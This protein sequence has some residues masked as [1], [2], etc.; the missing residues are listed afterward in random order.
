V[1][2]TRVRQKETLMHQTFHPPMTARQ[3]RGFTLV[4]LLVVIGIIALLISMLLPSL[5][6]ARQAANAAACLSNM[7]QIGQ[8]ALMFAN[9][10]KG[11]LPKNWN[12]A[13]PN[14]GDTS[15]EY[16]YPFESWEYILSLYSSKNVFRC[17][18]D[19][20]GKLRGQWTTQDW[21]GDK[22][23][24][25]DIPL[26]YRWN[27]SHFPDND[28][29]IKLSQ[30]RNSTQ[31]ILAAEGAMV[32]EFPENWLATWTSNYDTRVGELTPE[33]AAYNRHGG[34]TIAQGRS[35][36]VFADGHA[37]TLDWAETWKRIGGTDDQPETMWRTKW[38]G[39]KWNGGQPLTNQSP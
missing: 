14:W 19:D 21:A 22:W 8:A 25:D 1:P 30:L 35:N 3:R 23:E 38:L 9:D 2:Q 31:A 13:G 18:S 20:T 32:A 39:S 11:Y 5:N 15:W 24:D 28:T 12:N 37:E 17:P 4:E 6:K 29:G 36:F 34:K 7:R 26:S 10:H 27:M 16:R 33:N